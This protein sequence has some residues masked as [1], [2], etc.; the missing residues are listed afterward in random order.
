MGSVQ[1]LWEYRDADAG[2]CLG[3]GRYRPHSL[4]AARSGSVG[5]GPETRRQTRMKRRRS[6]GRGRRP[7]QQARRRYRDHFSFCIHTSSKFSHFSPS[8][9]PCLSTTHRIGIDTD[10]YED[11][12]NRPRPEPP[13]RLPSTS[14]IRESQGAQAAQHV[15]FGKNLCIESLSNWRSSPRV[16]GTCP[17]SYIVQHY[18]VSTGPELLRYLPD[19]CD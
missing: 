8:H 19:C 5:A 10:T 15:D 9:S 18:P 6:H 17:L 3:W 16:V 1:Q 2:R 14:R 4:F 7:F 13:Q 11:R 12:Q